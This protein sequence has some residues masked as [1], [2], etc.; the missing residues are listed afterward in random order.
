MLLHEMHVYA[1]D[2]ASFEADDV[3]II[4]VLVK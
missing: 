4:H 2:C 3:V 1:E